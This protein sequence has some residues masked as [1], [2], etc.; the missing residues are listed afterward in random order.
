MTSC[1]TGRRCQPTELRPPHVESLYPCCL[2]LFD[3]L[4]FPSRALPFPAVPFGRA[5]T[6][7]QRGCDLLDFNGTDSPFLIL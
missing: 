6:G 4:E 7:Q 2:R 3:T 5:V 1:V